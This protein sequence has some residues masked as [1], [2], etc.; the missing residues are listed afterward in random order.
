VPHL[1]IC[2]QSAR[3]LPP[4]NQRFRCIPKALSIKALR[5]LQFPRS[6]QATQYVC[7]RSVGQATSSVSVPER[8]A[9]RIKTPLSPRQ[10]VGGSLDAFGEKTAPPANPANF[11]GCA[12]GMWRSFTA[13]TR[14]A[15]MNKPAART[16]RIRRPSQRAN[17][18]QQYPDDARTRA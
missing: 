10:S 18:A 11:A 9:T 17:E 8:A 6:T 7:F 5:P 2:R 13:I 15:K 14:G 4:P 3:R 1:A 16:R 12:V